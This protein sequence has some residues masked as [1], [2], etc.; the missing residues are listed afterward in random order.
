MA[1]GQV[2]NPDCRYARYI[3]HSALT[4]SGAPMLPNTPLSSE[5]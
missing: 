3:A 2:G 4:P 1:L 5:R